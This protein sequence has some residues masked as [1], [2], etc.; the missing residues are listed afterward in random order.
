MEIV[1]KFEKLYDKSVPIDSIQCD[2]ID[3]AIFKFDSNIRFCDSKNLIKHIPTG[4]N[5]RIEA[6]HSFVNSSPYFWMIP[7]KTPKG[8]IFGFVLK[9]YDKK[10]Y[11]N[12]FNEN[13]IS[14]FYGWADFHNFQ[15]NYPIILTEGVKDAIILKQIYPY[16]IATLTAGLHG[17]HDFEIMKSLTDKILLAYDNDKAGKNA[18]ENNFKK[19]SAMKLRVK[20]LFYSADDVG[21]LYNNHIGL[22]VLRN[23]IQQAFCNLQ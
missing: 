9:S 16:S 6:F 13:A 10:Q 2:T 18:T 23:S 11:R 3:Y 17:L 15:K 22:T 4:S 5:K 14:T 21:N 8:K 12:I 20:P 7:L 1:K 19:L